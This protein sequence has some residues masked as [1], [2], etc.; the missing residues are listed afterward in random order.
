MSIEL[1]IYK[2]RAENTPEMKFAGTP[3]AGV[4]VDGVFQGYASLFGVVDLA[5]DTVVPGAFAASL[6]QRGASG[7]KLLW[8]HNP[9]ELLGIWEI[10]AEDSRG[11]FVRGRLDLAVA[12]ARE[13]HAL[14]KSRAVDGLSIGFK[15]IRSRRDAATGQRRLEKIDLW[16]VSIVTFPMLP[17]ARVSAVKEV[18][19]E[20]RTALG[21]VERAIRRATAIIRHHL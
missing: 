5:G 18:L 8:Q 7:V 10:L 15:T 17:Q 2:S 13:V 20:P 6:A 4:T 16:E 11:L 9:A 1:P 3:L 19:P 21:A 12:R 14:M